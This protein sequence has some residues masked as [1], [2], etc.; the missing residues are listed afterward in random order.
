MGV[1]PGIIYKALE[2]YPEKVVEGKTMEELERMSCNKFSRRWDESVMDYSH[3][4]PYP[5][6]M[7]P[8][9]S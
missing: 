9:L 1:L 8:S 5:L 3:Q 7:A 4:M 2:N 6:H